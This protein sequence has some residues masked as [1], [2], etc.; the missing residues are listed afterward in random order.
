MVSKNP[1]SQRWLLFSFACALLLSPS[2]FQPA[3]AQEGSKGIRAEEVVRRIKPPTVR[4]AIAKRR[5]PP[6]SKARPPATYRSDAPFVKAQAPQSMEY[7]LVGV[8]IWRLQEG[9][10]DLK[11]E[12]EEAQQLEQVEANSPLSIGSRVRLGIEPLSRDG[13]LYVIDREQFADGSYG[14]PSL[15]FP[16][17]RTR[18]GNNQIKANQLVYIPMPPSYFRISPSRTGKAQVAEV[19][20]ILYSPTPLDLPAPTDKPLALTPEQ[21]KEWERLWGTQT[22]RLEMEGGAGTTTSAKAQTEGAKSLEQ[23]GEEA[24]LTEDDPLPQSVFRAAIK[25]GNPLLV[26]VPLVFGNK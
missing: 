16:T 18:K 13:Y 23:E 19:I 24:Q 5:T 20:T 2:G 1:I 9:S 21:V 22:N 12:G 26:T 10:K 4:I 6:A 11:Q 7:A 3:R 17:L 14:T 15:I 8:T 25:V